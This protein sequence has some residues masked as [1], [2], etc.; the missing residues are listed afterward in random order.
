MK[1]SH[2]R[3]LVREGNDLLAA[4][5][6]EDAAA[7]YRGALEAD[8]SSLDARINLGFALNELGKL[9][10]AREHLERA[11]RMDPGSADAHYLLGLVAEAQSDADTAGGYLTAAVGIKPDFTHAW[12]DLCRVQFHA[13]LVEQAIRSAEQGL[14]IDGQM[15]ELHNFLGNIYLHEKDCEQALACYD[16]AVAINPGFVEAHGNRGLALHEL[17]RF[18]EALESFEHALDLR[19]D[20]PEGI[21]GASLTRLLLGD[22][23]RGWIEYERRWQHVENQG[24]REYRMALRNYDRPRWHGE[25][26]VRGQTILLY[27]EQGLGDTIQFCRYAERVAALGARVVLEVPPALGTLLRGMR[28]VDQLVL[29][30]DSLPSFDWHCPL[31]SLPLVFKS[32]LHDISGAPYL[33][34]SSESMAAWEAR[35][36]ERWQPRV[37]LVWSGGTA[38][39]NDRNRSIPLAQFRGGLVPGIHYFCLQKEIRPADRELLRQLTEIRVFDKQLHDF[40]DTAALIALMDV[41]ITVDTSVAHLAGALGKETWVLLPGVP[42]WRWLLGRDDS[43]WYGSVRLI[44]Q[45][46]IGDWQSV[47][48]EVESRLCRL[49]AE[50]TRKPP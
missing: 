5:K 38:H 34:A 6:V 20:F 42:D 40:A 25:A 4:G 15:A 47:M 46:H 2:A 27:P 10:E 19:P 33:E 43:P 9:E 26:D 30:G 17:G 37:G 32:G 45:P 29:S 44:R 36:G 24:S 31:M 14:A 12:R 39:K 11:I 7:R 41:V 48:R 13:G 16:K 50:P 18:K 49:L 3:L 35:L 28:G 21:Y 8:A 1:L 22:F 23:E